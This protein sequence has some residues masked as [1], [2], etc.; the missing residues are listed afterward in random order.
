M[1]IKFLGLLI[2][3]GLFCVSCNKS[4]S[5]APQPFTTASNVAAHDYTQPYLTGEKIQKFLQSM[6]EGQ[7]PFEYLFAP[8][9]RT[10][11]PADLATRMAALD[12]FARKYGFQG[13]QDYVA[14]WGRIVAGQVTIMADGMKQ[15][16]RDIA[17]K[18]IQSAQE[19]LKN[20]NLSADMR[21]VYEQ[22]IE[23]AKTSLQQLDQ[24]SRNALNANDL[25][26]VKKYS[27]QITEASRKY[28]SRSVPTQ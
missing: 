21:K 6:S 28:N 9:N 11:T 10:A 20:P 12:A 7:N 27:P 15:S 4:S 8:G 25:A 23:G 24:P 17:E 13:Y 2:L 1:N 14:V 19:Q 16:A 18:S 26:L 3:A 22:Q 5:S